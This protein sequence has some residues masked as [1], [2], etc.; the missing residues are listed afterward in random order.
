MTRDLDWGSVVEEM[1]GFWCVEN[2]CEMTI[3][4]AESKMGGSTD[5]GA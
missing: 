3:Q 2:G 1:E 5:S 4:E